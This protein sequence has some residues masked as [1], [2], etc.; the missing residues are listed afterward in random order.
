MGERVVHTS[1]CIGRRSCDILTRV[2]EHDVEDLVL[3]TDEHAETLTRAGVP[4]LTRLVHAARDYGRAVPV[5]LSAANLRL[6]TD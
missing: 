3:V 4:Y 1:G 6:V 2:V 5:E